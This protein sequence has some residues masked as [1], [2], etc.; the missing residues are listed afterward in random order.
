[1]RVKKYRSRSVV[2]SPLEDLGLTHHIFSAQDELCHNSL[3]HCELITSPCIIKCLALGYFNKCASVTYKTWKPTYDFV[4]LH[5]QFHPC[6]EISGC[7]GGEYVFWD[8]APC[9]L[10]DVY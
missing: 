4:Q 5:K 6:G 3:V 7:H 9:I 10:V 8:V 1:V 2:V